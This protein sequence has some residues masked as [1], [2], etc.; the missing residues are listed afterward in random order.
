M[1][2]FLVSALKAVCCAAPLL[3]DERYCEE[4]HKIIAGSVDFLPVE[5]SARLLKTLEAT[6]KFGK[7]THVNVDLFMK[8]IIDELIIKGKC[9]DLKRTGNS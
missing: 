9:L 3:K 4:I 2:L 5:L 8:E 6:S 1:L 7:N